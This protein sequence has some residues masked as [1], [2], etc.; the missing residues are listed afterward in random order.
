MAGR[1]IARVE[2]RRDLRFPQPLG[3]AKRLT[4]RRITALSRRAKYLLAHLDDGWIWATHL[5]MSGRFIVNPPD[6]GARGAA[7]SG[8]P[9]AW[10]FDPKHDH[11][12]A[13]LADGGRVAFNDPRRFG[14]MLLVHGDEFD[15]HPRFAKLGPEPLSNAFNATVLAERLAGKRGPIKAALLDQSVVAGLGN[16]YVCEALF[17][18]RLSPTRAAGTVSGVKAERLV[19]AI[20]TVL[21]EAIAAG[22]SSLRDY[23][24]ASGELG[25]FQH[26]FAVYGR[27]GEPCP[28]CDCKTGIARL[29]QSGRSTFHCAKRQT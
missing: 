18:A 9:A 20:R 7:T 10:A 2:S 11:V 29:A 3:F 13:E 25:Y 4:G 26:A 28:G 27:E 6:A 23:V 16:I 1:A 17:R 14:Y 24:Q 21:S 19:D 22:G 5:G 8:Q 12:T 15:A